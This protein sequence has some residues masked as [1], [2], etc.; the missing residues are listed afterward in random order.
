MSHF[1]RYSETKPV[2]VNMGISVFQN[3][4]KVNH[5][6]NLQNYRAITHGIPA[7]CMYQKHV[8]I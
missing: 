5:R 7:L 2:G 6:L 3:E 8:I 4:F 1:D